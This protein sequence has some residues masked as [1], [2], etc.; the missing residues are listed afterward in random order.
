MNEESKYLLHSPLYAATS[1]MR[2]EIALALEVL[3]LGLIGQDVHVENAGQ[4]SQVTQMH[5]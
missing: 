4:E 2:E 3:V 1:P 5:M